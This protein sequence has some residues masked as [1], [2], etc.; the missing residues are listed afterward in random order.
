[1]Y[2]D[3][4]VGDGK[5][6]AVGAVVGLGG[7]GVSVAGAVDVTTGIFVV[8]G[9]CCRVGLAQPKIKHTVPRITIL[10]Q[11]QKNLYLL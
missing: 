8:V 11:N 3:S 5:T 9:V 7:R 2:N 10:Q 6:V 4:T 1:M